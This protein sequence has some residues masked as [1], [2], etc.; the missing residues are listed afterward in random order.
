MHQRLGEFEDQRVSGIKGDIQLT[1]Q[2]KILLCIVLR[3]TVDDSSATKGVARIK[4]GPDAVVKRIA[5]VAFNS[6]QRLL[7]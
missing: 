2:D 7:P 4:R 5:D 3:D 1:A 6:G